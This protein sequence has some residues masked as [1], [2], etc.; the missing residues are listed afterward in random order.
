M[1]SG[2]GCGSFVKVAVEE[3]SGGGTLPTCRTAVD[4]YA[5]DVHVGV[6]FG[7]LLDPLDSVRES[8]VNEVFIAEMGEV[9]VAECGAES[10]DLDNNKP[11]F[12]EFVE[13]SV[14][15]APPI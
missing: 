5:G 1:A 11:S 8:C 4:T 3:D 13:I 15:S 14:K 6:F 7:G 10:I 12:G 9:A 2:V